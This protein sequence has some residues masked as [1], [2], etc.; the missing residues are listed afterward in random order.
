[1]YLLPQG[2]VY[3]DIAQRYLYVYQEQNLPFYYHP[4]FP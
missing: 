2:E 1:M 3:Q 4:L